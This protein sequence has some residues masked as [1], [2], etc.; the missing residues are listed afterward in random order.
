MRK[1]SMNSIEKNAMDVNARLLDCIKNGVKVKMMGEMSHERT[2]LNTLEESYDGVRRTDALL[3]FYRE[4][5]R[6]FFLGIIPIA[7]AIV[8]WDVIINTEDPA[9]AVDIGT[10]IFVAILLLGE[11]HKALI[12]LPF[13][14]DKQV[15]ANEAQSII[16]RFLGEGDAALSCRKPKVL[17]Q[18]SSNEKTANSSFCDA[19]A[20][21]GYSSDGD[22][23]DEKRAAVA[24][25][26]LIRPVARK[27]IRDV[28]VWSTS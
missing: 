23:S 25:F 10:S 17:A 6:N 14:L 2:A 18:P 3:K 20:G 28:E 13:V 27:R 8:A 1:M 22:S 21:G 7:M 24:V 11:G 12:H 26:N 4:G 5:V 9:T 19:E 15:G 16:D